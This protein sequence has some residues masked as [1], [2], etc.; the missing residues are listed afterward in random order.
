MYHLS[1]SH[2]GMFTFQMICAGDQVF[3][4]FNLSQKAKF[5]EINHVAE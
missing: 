3:T 4:V 1:S 5:V 2:L